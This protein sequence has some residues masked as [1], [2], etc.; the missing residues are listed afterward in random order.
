MKLAAEAELWIEGRKTSKTG[1]SREFVTPPLSPNESFVYEV[2][3][4]WREGERD[5]EQ[6]RAL[7]P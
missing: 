7:I 5:V 2:R 1:A 6:T 4:R 3:A